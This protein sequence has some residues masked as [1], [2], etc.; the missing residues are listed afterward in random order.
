MLDHCATDLNNSTS[1]V[2]LLDNNSIPAQS[3]N[4]NIFSPGDNLIYI[5][6]AGK[7]DSRST[8]SLNNDFGNNYDIFF[9]KSQ[10][11]GSTFSKPLNLSNNY[12][13]S[14]L[15]QIFAVYSDTLKGSDSNQSQGS[16]N[17]TK[18]AN[19]NTV[20]VVWEDNSSLNDADLLGKIC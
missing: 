18:N 1:R 20:Y 17:N 10:D 8:P 14:T 5:T 11:G 7:I 4:P 6:W 2:S 15:P 12:G 19:N 9:V 13:I 16:N 3:Y